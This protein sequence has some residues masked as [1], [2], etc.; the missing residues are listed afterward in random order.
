MKKDN[1]VEDIIKSK[2]ENIEI[3]LK[4]IE[5]VNKNIPHR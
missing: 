1:T 4:E 2:V 3:F 5:E